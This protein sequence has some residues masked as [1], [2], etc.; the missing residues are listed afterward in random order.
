LENFQM[1][2]G[3]IGGGLIVPFVQWLKGKIQ[4]VPFVFFLISNGMAIGFGFLLNY[5]LKAGLDVNTVIMTSLAVI[6]TA[7]QGVH[8]V[9]KT[10]KKLK[11]GG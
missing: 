7:A 6:G 4:D 1:L 5:L 2:L 8:A 3:M 9:I 10:K 11:N